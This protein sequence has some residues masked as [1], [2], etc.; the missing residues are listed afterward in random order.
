MPITSCIGEAAGIA[1]ALAVESACDCKDVNVKLLQ[2]KL[3]A[4]NALF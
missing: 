2:G 4:Y 1:A 3:Q